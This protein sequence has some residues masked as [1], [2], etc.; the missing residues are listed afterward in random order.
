MLSRPGDL[1]PSGGSTFG[2]RNKGMP[3]KQGAPVDAGGDGGGNRKRSARAGAAARSNGPTAVGG[4]GKGEA[5]DSVGG[6]VRGIEDALAAGAEGI[7]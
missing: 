6:P 1:A 7:A 5:G 2:L 3:C 4:D